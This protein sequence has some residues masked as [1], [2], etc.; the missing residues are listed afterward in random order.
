MS[1]LDN[2]KECVFEIGYYATKIKPNL[3]KINGLIVANQNFTVKTITIDSFVPFYRSQYFRPRTTADFYISSIDRDM[4]YRDTFWRIGYS[5]YIVRHDILGEVCPYKNLPDMDKHFNKLDLLIVGVQNAKSISPNIVITKCL[6]GVK[7]NKN[8]FIIPRVHAFTVES[9]SILLD[10]Y[11]VNDKFEFRPYKFN[12]NNIPLNIKTSIALVDADENKSIPSFKELYYKKS[13]RYLKDERYDECFSVDGLVYRDGIFLM[14]NG[15]CFLDRNAT[16]TD[17]L[18]FPSD[19]IFIVNKRVNSKMHCIKHIV[20]NKGIEDILNISKYQCWLSWN[21]S[22]ESLYFSKDTD[23]KIVGNICISCFIPYKNTYYSELNN[24]LKKPNL[25]K[26]V[27]L[28]Y[29][30]FC[31]SK[32]GSKKKILFY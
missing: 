30:E 23:I 19:C 9:N 12:L 3:Y 15:Y 28:D 18:I 7:T 26:K 22:I 13:I 21:T 11:Y 20:F 14:F 24:L 10:A 5:Y 32:V 4:G 31:L 2:Y 1:T 25:D 17:S 6:L 29:L 27:F 16:F 8:E